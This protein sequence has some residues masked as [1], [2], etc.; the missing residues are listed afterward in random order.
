VELPIPGS[1][2]LSPGIVLELLV[3]VQPDPKYKFCC[4]CSVDDPPLYFLINS[5][6]NSYIEQREHLLEQQV[7]IPNTELDDRLHSNSYLDCSQPFGNLSH[8]EVCDC[9]DANQGCFMG[10][11]SDEILSQIVIV[12]RDSMT[13]RPTEKH[14]ILLALVK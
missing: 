12:V 5:S 2:I 9:I 7:L 1:Q 14:G 11:I 10:R 4:F 8:Q 13:I 3:P 6:I